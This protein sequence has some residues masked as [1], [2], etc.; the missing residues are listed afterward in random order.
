MRRIFLALCALFLTVTAVGH[1]SAE[2]RAIYQISTITALKEG[3]YDGRATF[4]ELKEHGDLGI[5]TLNGL[6]GEMIALDGEF[7]QIKV[8][9][10]AYP[11]MDSAITPFAIVTFFR[12]ELQ[13]SLRNLP[14]FLSL[15]RRLDTLPQTRDNFCAIRIDGT[16]AYLKVRSVAG[17]SKPYPGLED[18][19][20]NQAV[21]E[22]KGVRG[23]LVGFRFPLY[24][25]GVNVPGYHFHFI[26]ED[27]K[28]GGHLLE[29]NLEEGQAGLAFIAALDLRL[30]EQDGT[31]GSERK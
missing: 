15:Q 16:F 11:I 1:C 20:K 5:G 29:C 28:Q 31:G 10:K 7:F 17:Q 2:T 30:N 4:R 19:L 14:N 25:E 9:G 6:D 26:T 3:V 22:L 27:K 21:F 23:T 24:M 12:P 13:L 18:A 8:D